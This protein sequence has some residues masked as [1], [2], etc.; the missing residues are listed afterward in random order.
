MS[1]KTQMQTYF[2][3]NMDRNGIN[4]SL[5]KGFEKGNETHKVARAVF[6]PPVHIQVINVTKFSKKHQNVSKQEGKLKHQT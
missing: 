6:V 4:G 5:H 2:I 1:T 3:G